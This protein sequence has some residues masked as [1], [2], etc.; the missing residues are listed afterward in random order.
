MNLTINRNYAFT[1]VQIHTKALDGGNVLVDSELQM[2]AAR[3]CAW[4]W[5]VLTTCSGKP[6]PNQNNSKQ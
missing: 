5:S 2:S 4:K 6:K 3:Q 1:A